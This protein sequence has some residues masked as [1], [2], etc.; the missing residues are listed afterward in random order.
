M[1]RFFDKGIVLAL[2]A[3]LLAFTI[4]NALIAYHNI[5]DLY[6]ARV[7]VGQSREVQKSLHQLLGTA[8]TA[9]AGVRGY[10]ITGEARYL[11]PYDRA[12][13]AN[14]KLVARLKDLTAASADQRARLAS[15]AARARDHIAELAAI[16]DARARGVDAAQREMATERGR[17]GMEELRRDVAEMDQEE[18]AMLDSRAQASVR[19]MDIARAS[20]A[21]AAILGVLMI[22][23][24]IYQMRRNLV[25]RDRAAAGLVAQKELFRTT[26][27]SLGEAVVTC[28]TEGRVNFLNGA[29]ETLT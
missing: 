29:A 22:V 25:A 1:Q 13:E 12:A 10:V 17:L 24:L 18:A 16:R 15:V 20:S 14:E 19:S 3:A 27:A 28:D 7:R 2:V 21:L 8:A 11:E 23:A 5:R 26:L 9:E 4:A 6:D